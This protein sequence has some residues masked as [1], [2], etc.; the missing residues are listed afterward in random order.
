MNWPEGN[1]GRTL[2]GTYLI[3]FVAMVIGLVWTLYNQATGGGGAQL[4][5]GIALFV[6]AQVVIT[7]IAFGLRNALPGK[8]DLGYQQAWHRLTL[9]RELATAARLLRA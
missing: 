7:A 2:A 3:A 9:G 1:K 4:A 5:V 8:T 6:V